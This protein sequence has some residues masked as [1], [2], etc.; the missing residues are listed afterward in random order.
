MTGEDRLTK[1]ERENYLIRL[2]KEFAY[3]GAAIPERIAVDGETVR[4]RAY[5]FDLSKKKGRLT[6]EEQADV[7]R[8]A[9]LV[10]RLRRDIVSRIAAEDLAR[11]E[12]ESLYRTAL[13]LGRALDTLGRAHQPPSSVKEETRKAKV[14]DGRRWLNLVKKVYA[15]E[16]KG[17]EGFQ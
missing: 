8:V 9:G 11:Q 16:R 14:E 12:A 6:P 15:K 5:V 1:V 13:G 7:D 17:R 10:R 3:A 4:L 2:E